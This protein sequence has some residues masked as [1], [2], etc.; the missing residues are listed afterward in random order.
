MIMIVI[1]VIVIGRGIW[2][3]MAG[4]MIITM[5]GMGMIKLL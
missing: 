3:T 1:E 2:E 4:D 5:A